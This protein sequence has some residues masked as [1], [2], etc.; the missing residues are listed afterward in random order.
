MKRTVYVNDWFRFADEDILG[1]EHLVKAGG[2]ANVICFHA[3]QAAEKYFK[4][5]LAAHR[6]NV[7]KIHNLD[8]L[9][10]SCEHIDGHFRDLLEDVVFLNKFYIE[11]RYPGDL[12][13]FGMKT[14]QKALS[15]AVAIRDY[16]LSRF[17]ND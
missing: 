9:L 16:I 11:A 14:A 7:R 5:F 17:G 4:G 6:E 15:S 12:P 2:P 8:A 10:T 1:A 3:Q 13:E